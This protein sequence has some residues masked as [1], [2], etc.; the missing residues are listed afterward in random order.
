MIVIVMDK[1]G[2]ILFQCIAKKHLDLLHLNV[3]K[4]EVL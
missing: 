4:I 3:Y 1:E 2:V